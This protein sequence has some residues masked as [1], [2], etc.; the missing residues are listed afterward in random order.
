MANFKELLP[1]VKAMVFDVDGVLSN[2]TITLHPNGE[3]MR[4]IST[5]DGYALNYAVLKGI[6]LA[7]I[8]GAKTEAVR[9]RFEALGIKDVHI[10][11]QMKLQVFK[12]FL[13][14]QQL[15]ADEVLYMGDDIP[16]YEVMKMVGIPVCPADAVQEIKA[17]SL[18]IS[19]KKGG[20]GCVRDI[21]EQVLKAQGKWM[22]SQEAF[23]W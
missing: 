14:K 18:Y 5:K 19:D 23:G 1:T 6:P 11:V 3:P 13:T 22:D 10:G 20:D 12:D 16:D 2:S 15:N 4:T 8:T 17:L 7:I 9:M 21:V